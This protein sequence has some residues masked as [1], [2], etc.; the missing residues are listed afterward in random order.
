MHQGAFL[1]CLKKKKN[2]IGSLMLVSLS[3]K[4]VFYTSA[5]SCQQ[6]LPIR[7]IPQP[8]TEELKNRGKTKK[9]CEQGEKKG[10]QK[11][12]GIC[13]IKLQPRLHLTVLRNV[14]P[15]ILSANVQDE[16][17]TISFLF[18]LKRMLWLF[19]LLYR[20]SREDKLNFFNQ[21]K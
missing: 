9:L 12:K 13:K 17:Q 11:L 4:P 2:G 15:W 21:T 16:V 3:P 19:T 8:L 20:I 14:K 7:I 1:L 18:I 10:G 6:T 5:T